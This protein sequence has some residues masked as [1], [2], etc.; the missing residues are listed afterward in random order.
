[1]TDRAGRRRRQRRHKRRT[2]ARKRNPIRSLLTNDCPDTPEVR[3]W[4]R[5]VDRVLWGELVKASAAGL[6]R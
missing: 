4:L 6:P 2:A 5:E 1:M 3:R